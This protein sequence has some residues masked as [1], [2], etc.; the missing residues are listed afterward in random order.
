M[1]HMSRN[2]AAMILS[3]GST[4][5]TCRVYGQSGQ[6]QNKRPMEAPAKD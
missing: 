5:G 4:E 1:D 6:K 3:A 2:L